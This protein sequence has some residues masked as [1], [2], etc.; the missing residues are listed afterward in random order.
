MGR[1]DEMML[2][3]R[4]RYVLLLLLASPLCSKADA[5]VD[6]ERH[7]SR[8]LDGFCS[9][10]MSSDQITEHLTLAV[11]EYEKNQGNPA[12]LAGRS[13]ALHVQGLVARGVANDEAAEA[14]F[15]ESLRLARMSID[16]VPSSDAYAMIADNYAQLMIVNGLL[17]R[18][19][20]GRKVRLNV[21]R[22]LDLDPAHVPARITL[23]LYHLNAPAFAGGDID[24]TVSLLKELAGENGLSSHQAFSVHAWLSIAH[25]RRG[26]S[27]LQKFHATE[28]RSIFPG[29][30]WLEEMDAESR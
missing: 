17:Y 2:R 27:G 11:E 9:E 12:A 15:I 21:E 18:I 6:A 26:E 23:A 20:T 19:T 1:F 16:A 28:A 10:S 4:V 8:A 29:N 25:G 22:A 5:M 14:A 7:L 30:T 24:R 13:R 3:T